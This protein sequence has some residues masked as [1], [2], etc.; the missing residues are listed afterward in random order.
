MR[1][2]ACAYV[3]VYVCACARRYELRR[4][5]RSLAVLT[6][7]LSNLHIV[8]KIN[9]ITGY[10]DITENLLVS[11]AYAATSRM[12]SSGRRAVYSIMRDVVRAR[13]RRARYVRSNC[14]V[15]RGR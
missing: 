14:G 9:T 1:A 10:V 4:I 6:S 5:S 2:R 8:G 3:C 12:I 13:V 7:R 11:S 15:F